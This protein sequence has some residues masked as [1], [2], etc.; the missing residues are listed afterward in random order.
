MANLSIRKYA[1]HRGISHV[2]VLK[3]IKSGRI[4]KAADG[5]ID[6]ATADV[7]WEKNTNPGQQ[8]SQHHHAA[9]RPATAPVSSSP[10]ASVESIPES[11][12]AAGS[13]DYSKA[14]AV[15]ENY[16]ARMAKLDFEERS[17]KLMSRDEVEVAA[18][19]KFR[20]FRDSMLNIPDRM[21]SVLAAE[22]DPTRVHSLLSDEIR[23][24]LT[25]FADA[26][27]RR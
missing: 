13:L 17:D 21:A 14:R 10:L 5:S 25:E 16:L 26:A 11:R 15:R 6:V 18:F 7:D 12:S 2:S 23:K 24:M 19:K 27:D 9:A 22:S 8:A 20:D 1:A 3:A 4:E